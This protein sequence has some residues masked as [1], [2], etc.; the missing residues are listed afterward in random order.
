MKSPL[1]SCS[2]SFYAVKEGIQCS[3]KD[4]A[5]THL[6][7]CVLVEPIVATVVTSPLLPPSLLLAFTCVHLV[8]RYDQ[9]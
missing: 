4:V 1:F 3:S 6:D 7:R 2:F 8:I 9:C 5:P